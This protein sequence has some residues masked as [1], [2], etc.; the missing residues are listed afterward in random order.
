MRLPFIA[1]CGAVSYCQSNRGVESRA[2]PAGMRTNNALS[3]PPAS[4]S[5][6]LTSGF[7]ESRF[8]NTEPAEPDPTMM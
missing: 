6:T 4:S 3:E 2:M 7:A 1:G 5:S 8:A